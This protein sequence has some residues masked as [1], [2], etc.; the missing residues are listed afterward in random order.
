MALVEYSKEGT[1][2]SDKENIAKITLNRPDKFNAL[3]YDLLKE[4]SAAFDKAEAD[5]EIRAV[6]ITGSGKAFSSGADLGGVA[7]MSEEETIE[8]TKF[9]QEVFRKIENFPKAV[10]AA[11]NGYCFGGGLEMAI[12]CDI[13]I[14][15]EE[16]KMG[17]PEVGIG[18]IP[19]WGGTQRMPYLVGQSVA[20]EMVLTGNRYS[21]EEAKDMGIVSKVVPEDELEST[22]AFMAAKVADN[23]PLAVSFA[24]QS[25]KATRTKSI[26]DGNQ[27]EFDFFLKLMKSEDLQ[28]G[29]TAFQSKRKPE[30]KGR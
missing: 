22:A 20:R 19:A 9:G 5:P 7:S 10:I 29:I 16:A 12:S 4:L 15:S 3:S 27:M 26:E 30:F 24:K 8:F 25:L 28:E 14:A 11:I 1:F 23:A 6:V 17:F 18:L 13:R 2:L 21:G